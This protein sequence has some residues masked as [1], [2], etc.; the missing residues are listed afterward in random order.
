MG[1]DLI[2]LSF[3]EVAPSLRLVRAAVSN[4]QLE[5]LNRFRRYQRLLVFGSGAL[6]TAMMLLTFLMETRA[7]ALRHLESL[8]QTFIAE[9]AMQLKEIDARENAFRIVLVGA[10]IIW[11]EGLPFDLSNVH[12]FRRQGR[13]L[14]LESSSELR[15]QWVFGSGQLEGDEALGR[16]F[17]LAKQV[18]RATTVDR[19]VK[20]E[21]LSSYFYSLHHNIAGIIPAPGHVERERIATDRD[22][23]LRMLTSDVDRRI[24]LSS[25]R[26]LL[27][28]KQPLYWLPPYTNPYT[29]QRV[30][31]IAGPML[32]QGIP[33]AALVMEYAP[34]SCQ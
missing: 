27:D 26:K 22:H 32:E 13:Q 2:I 12:D 16:F 21:V 25:E 33:F 29:G 5:A 18:G 8:R 23:Y 7:T 28:N 24:F 1:R 20:G 14:L 34:P 15:P 10:E 4:L 11:R 3:Y 31:R 17:S 9:H 30:L 19:M 6:T